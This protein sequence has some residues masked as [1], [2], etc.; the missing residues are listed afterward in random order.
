MLTTLADEFSHEAPVVIE[1]LFARIFGSVIL[2]GLIGLERESR[3]NP[4]GLRTNML[5]GLAA[6]V[7]A[8]VGLQ[9]MHEFGNKPDTVQIDPIRLVEAVTAGI[10]FLAA[11]VIIYTRGDVKGLTT[12][13]S[14]WLSGAIGLCVGL[15]MWLVAVVAT[16]VGIIILW[17]LRKTEVAVGTKEE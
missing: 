3:R 15:G 8:L 7:F 11:G 12:G 17:L 4:A 16:A 9:I 5:I 13:A 6:T 14:M 1:V 2:C 10:A